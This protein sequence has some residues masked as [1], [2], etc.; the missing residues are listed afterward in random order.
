MSM[1]TIPLI[2]VAM[3]ERSILIPALENVLYSGMVGEGEHVYKFEKEFETKFNLK[4]VLAVNSGTAALHI[5]LILSGVNSGDEVLTTSMTAEPTNT[6]ILNCGAIPV[7][8]D[9]DPNNGNICINS[10]R[11]KLS[12]KTKAICVVH[13]AGYPVDIVA[14]RKLADEYHIPLIEDCAHALGAKVEGKSVGSFGDYAIFS[15]QAIKHITTIDGGVLVVKNVDNVDRAK[16]LRWFGMP[17]GVSRTELDIVE[18]GYKYNM[19]NVTATFGLAQMQGVDELIQKHRENGLFFDDAFKGLTRVF[20]AS[21]YNG[22]EGSYWI[23]TLLC[24]E[25]EKLEKRLIENGIIASKL[26]RPNHYHSVFQSQSSN[27][28]NLEK[29]YKKLLHIPCGWWLSEKDRNSIKS[30]VASF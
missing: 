1:K 6:T 3:P 11:E 20:P 19:N 17:K 13:Y 5:A 25:S 18:A 22:S 2:K 7:F 8:C 10:A 24:D 12:P 29:F 23:Y 14:F 21:N 30:I 9:V 28:P 15:F 16:R 26:H 4:N 27:L